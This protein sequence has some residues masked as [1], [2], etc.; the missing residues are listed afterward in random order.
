MDI[1]NNYKFYEGF[2]GEQEIIFQIVEDNNTS[3]HL[4][5][6]YIND[7]MNN[8][9]G[10]EDDYKIGLSHDWNSLEGPYSNDSKKTINVDDYY[11]DLLRFQ[12]VQFKYEETKELYELLLI[13]LKYAKDNNKKVEVIVD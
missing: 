2:E 5:E 11:K 4:W 6:G 3:I 10:M 13:F 1:L 12:N 7:I 9:P 8:Q